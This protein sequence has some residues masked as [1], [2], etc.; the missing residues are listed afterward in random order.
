MWV[1]GLNHEWT[2]MWVVRFEP[3]MDTNVGGGFEPRMGSNV[4]GWELNHEWTR[5]DG[6]GWEWMGM[7]GMDGKWRCRGVDPC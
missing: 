6:N 5:M 7:M 1:V 3:R 4:G 2:R